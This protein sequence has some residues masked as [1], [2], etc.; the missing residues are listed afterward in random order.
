MYVQLK[1]I[2][3]PFS[4]IELESICTKHERKNDVFLGSERLCPFNHET[5]TQAFLFFNFVKAQNF[6]NFVGCSNSRR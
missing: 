2:Q 4:Q 6:L 1:I 5:M 3:R